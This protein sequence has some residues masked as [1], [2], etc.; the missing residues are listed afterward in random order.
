M[1]RSSTLNG[2]SSR[3]YVSSRVSGN[4]SQTRWDEEQG[5]AGTPRPSPDR[6][7]GTPTRTQPRQQQQS[8]STLLRQKSADSTEDSVEGLLPPIKTNR[9]TS[10]TANRN[11]Q[12]VA[13][14]PTD[15]NTKNDYNNQSFSKSIASPRY[16]S[17]RS[18]L[19][20]R[21]SSS[22]VNVNTSW[23]S[24]SASSRSSTH[25][26][27]PASPPTTTTNNGKSTVISD[28]DDDSYDNFG[29]RPFPNMGRGGGG[30]AAESSDDGEDFSALQER[31][32][33]RL[34]S[35]ASQLQQDSEHDEQLMAKYEQDEQAYLRQLQAI[36]HQ[37]QQDQQEPSFETND[38]K[39]PDNGSKPV[40][41]A[42]IVG[43]AGRGATIDSDN[44]EYTASR[45]IATVPGTPSG[46]YTTFSA[47]SS[48][49]DGPWTP[50]G[51]KRASS[52]VAPTGA[53][54]GMDAGEYQ[55][56]QNGEA[57]QMNPDGTVSYGVQFPHG[58]ENGLGNRTRTMDTEDDD[59]ASGDVDPIISS[60]KNNGVAEDP[61]QRQNHNRVMWI[62]SGTGAVLLVVAVVLVVVF[63]LQARNNNNDGADPSNVQSTGDRNIDPDIA[64]AVP[65]FVPALSPSHS[66]VVDTQEPVADTAAP[67][68][69]LPT[70]RPT[71]AP[72]AAP[73]VSPTTV[74]STPTVSPTMAPTLR[75]TFGS[76]EQEQ[77]FDLLSNYTFPRTI[78]NMRI[79]ETP[80]RNALD[81]LAGSSTIED[82]EQWGTSRVIQRFALASFYYGSNGTEWDVRDDWLE[83][84]DEECN[85]LRGRDIE[86]SGEGLVTQ[87]VLRRRGIQG[88]L[89]P[90]IGLLTNLEQLTLSE[91]ALEGTL[92]PE[93]SSLSNLQEISLRENRLTGPIPEE[94]K[95]L[96][97]LRLIRLHE[98]D[99][100]GAVPRTVC[101]S[102]L[103]SATTFYSDCGGT[104]P[105]IQC[106][107][108]FCCTYCCEDGVGCGCVFEDTPLEDELC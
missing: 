91:N 37:Q 66:P 103:V 10:T 12:P 90:E 3:A 57:L 67:T 45:P 65:S 28:S 15:I 76:A 92:P 50:A 33:A 23:T 97:S 59:D 83:S 101:D 31:L 2:G 107:P 81:W 72:T 96:T 14:S 58:D 39:D 63:L 86:C 4:Q 61:G 1:V 95:S 42:V 5:N 36:A 47:T 35:S 105:E 94:W 69:A 32:Q 17:Y 64:A 100:S 16:S 85:W 51:A 99:L 73:T 30:K 27:L 44:P 88:T 75:P 26:P 77:L 82:W 74:T 60:S 19:A 11:Q 104:T 6:T 70:L 84:E 43:V 106:P 41:S 18:S 8:S 108:G 78:A 49:S 56:V 7:H 93:W 53:G 24:S 20:Q 55:D 62:L 98:N 71:A 25:S 102:W 29:P 79:L 89:V 68:T 52:K 13:V 22:N 34:Q 21:V 46:R 87:L 54:I 40:T 9:I 48:L 38:E 80:Q